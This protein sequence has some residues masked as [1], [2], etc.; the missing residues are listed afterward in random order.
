M[1]SLL[2][3][4][5]SFSLVSIIFIGF[6]LFIVSSA[7]KHLTVLERWLVAIT[8]GIIAWALLLYGLSWIDLRWLSLALVVGGSLAGWLKWRYQLFD[9]VYRIDRIL[10]AIIVVG[11][12]AQLYLVFPNGLLFEDGLRFYGINA[13]DGMWHVTL[14]ETLQRPFPPQMPTYAGVGLKGYHFLIDL[15][16]SEL[17]RVFAI[18]PVDLTFRWF[19]VLFSV[20]SGLSVFALLRR[21]T[22][23]RISAYFGVFLTYAAG[24][25][26]YAL[27]LVGN[28]SHWWETAFWA[29]QSI[30]TFIN[31]P[32]GVSFAILPVILLLTTI[33]FES[34][35]DSKLL[36]I[37]ALLVG[38]MI[39]I[40]AYGGVLT[41]VGFVFVLTL[42]GLMSKKLAV[43]GPILL[44][45]MIAG[46]LLISQ[47]QPG[48]GSFIWQPGWFL[49]TMMES[50]DRVH[51][52]IWEL[53]R[54]TYVSQ[55]NIPRL[56]QLWLLAFVAFFVGNMG[57]RIIGF[58]PVIREGIAARKR[59]SFVTAFMLVI[60]ILGIVLPMLV[61]QKGVL[62]N[63]I[64]FI[65]YSLFVM[66]IFTA[67]FVDSIKSERK[68]IALL[69]ILV[70]LTMPTTIQTLS[71]YYSDYQIQDYLLISHDE[72]EALSYIQQLPD[73]TALLT[74]YSNTSY[75][76]AFSG[77]SVFY[78]DEIQASIFL[79]PLD[80]GN[81]VVRVFCHDAKSGEIKD[82]M[83]ANNLTH[84]YVTKSNNTD[85]AGE[86][87]NNEL[88]DAVFANSTAAVYELK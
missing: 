72:L 82:L 36:W 84:V 3:S 79:L 14:M 56:I 54:Q 7:L 74:G 53:Q 66:N 25:L 33:Y 81:M 41:A 68:R 57:I 2:F 6:G 67:R 12:I 27:S 61:L 18:S 69:V 40:K 76:S 37:A 48:N 87:H 51:Y 73:N 30:T 39:S 23:R 71:T 15:W 28:Q 50:A 38:S 35:K 45:L 83:K 32:L 29:Q 42:Y 44:S 70:M 64:Q 24:S 16:G 47:L 5:L 22:K 8:V 77:K 52:P 46:L 80:R 20:L 17:A 55:N 13:H 26:G 9:G 58:V 78:A 11:V 60:V 1:T 59:Y 10:A 21:I 86:Y 4:I 85:C 75:V 34:K 62:W 43:L 88:M 65:Y 31:L 49:K 63:S 19:P